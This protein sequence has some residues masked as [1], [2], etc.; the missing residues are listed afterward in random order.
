MADN[1][2]TVAQPIWEDLISLNS[3][4]LAQFEVLGPAAEYREGDTHTDWSSEGDGLETALRRDTYPLPRTEDREGYYGQSHYSYWASGYRDSRL[5][6]E[7]CDR[8]GV[9]LR[10][11]LDLGCASG[12]VVRHFAVAGDVPEVYGCDLNRRHVDWINRFLPASAIAFQNHAIPTLPLPDNSIDAVSAYSVFTHIEAFETAWLMELRRVLRP[13]GIA[14]ITL[15][16]ERT[17]AT[18]NDNWGLYKRLR[19]HPDFAPYVDHANREELPEERMVFRWYADRSYSSKVFYQRDYVHKM[20]SR[21]MDVREDHH[22]F[23]SRQDVVILQ[24]A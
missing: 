17:W 12:R 18:M 15:H 19:H 23:P 7:A 11:Y 24:K 13:G 20:W 5:L 8:L 16:T 6:R 1:G 4:G 2:A 22:R 10:G 21:I 14:W 9:D 3:R